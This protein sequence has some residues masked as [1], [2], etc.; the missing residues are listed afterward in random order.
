MPDKESPL[1]KI[2]CPCC[3]SVLTVDVSLATVLSHK[4]PVR[5]QPVAHLKDANRLLKEEATRRD[6]KVQNIRDAEKNK[7]EVLEKKFQELLKKAKEE[8]L[9]KPIKDIDLD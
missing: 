1:I 6:E 3:G 2:A 8:P 7:G 5:P 9:E 4:E